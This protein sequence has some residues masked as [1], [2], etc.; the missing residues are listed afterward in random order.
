MCAK[1]QG[2]LQNFL[3]SVRKVEEENNRKFGRLYLRNGW[4]DFLEIW[5][6]DSPNWQAIL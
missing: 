4:D 6:V 5:N 2:V 3:H 1:F